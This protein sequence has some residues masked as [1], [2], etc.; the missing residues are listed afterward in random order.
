MH[1]QDTPRLLSVLAIM[2]AAKPSLAV[3]QH[4]RHFRLIKAVLLYRE[5]TLVNARSARHL[6]DFSRNLLL[7]LLPPGRICAACFQTSKSSQAHMDLVIAWLWNRS[8]VSVD[9][10]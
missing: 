7:H 9:D 8:A 10:S 5:A 6:S 1:L 2:A 3:R 4:S